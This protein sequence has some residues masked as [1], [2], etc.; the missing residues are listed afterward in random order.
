[1]DWRQAIFPDR[2][3]MRLGR[4]AFMGLKTILGIDRV[5]AIDNTVPGDLGDDACSR[6]RKTFRIALDNR[7]NIIREFSGKRIAVN[8]NPVTYE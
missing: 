3:A 5:K 6:N 7:L 2:R 8:K 1:M 4:V